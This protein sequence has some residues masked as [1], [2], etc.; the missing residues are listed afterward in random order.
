MT[1]PSGSATWTN[2][3]TARVNRAGDT[4]IGPL[5]VPPTLPPDPAATATSK[6]Y[7]DN[8]DSAVA[9]QTRAKGRATP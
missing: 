9:S 2:R 4:M 6:S 8:Q 5:L 1:R 3:L 7:V